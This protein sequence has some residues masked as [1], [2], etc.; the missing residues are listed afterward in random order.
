MKTT[1]LKIWHVLG[2]GAV[3]LLSACSNDD[4]P[5]AITQNK[6][7]FDAFV[8]KS[9][10]SNDITMT[11]FKEFSVYGMMENPTT[12]TDMATL[13]DNTQVSLNGTDWTYSPLRYWV[14]GNSYMFTA[15]A[16]YQASSSTTTPYWTFTPTTTLD[17]SFGY[18]GMGTISFNNQVAEANQDLIY[19]FA[20]VKDATATQP[21]VAFTFSHL[22]SRVMFTFENSFA[23][24]GSYIEISDVTI[25]NVNGAGSIDMTAASPA[26]TVTAGSTFSRT[27]GLVTNNGVEFNNQG[28]AET[29]WYYFIPASQTYDLTFTVKLYTGSDNGD[30]LAGTFQKSCTLP[31]VDMKPGYSYNFTASVDED[32]ISNTPLTPIKFTVTSIENWEDWSNAGSATYNK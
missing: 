5:I 21:P 8:N 1:Q 18:T 17:P 13:F 20:K 7:G 11:N 4:A 25:T 14:A 30:V 3:V 31:S 22:L 10:R 28:T 9:T 29:T 19:A 6:I 2:C 32:N 15:I 26:W 27:F 16:P 23:T 24:S 12:S